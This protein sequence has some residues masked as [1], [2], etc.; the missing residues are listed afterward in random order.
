MSRCVRRSHA[1]SSSPIRSR[2]SGCSTGRGL[3]RAAS[4]SCVDV[5]W[6]R[7]PG[8]IRRDRVGAD[9]AC[10]RAK[11]RR[12]GA[13]APRRLSPTLRSRRR[14][15]RLDEAGRAEASDAAREL[16]F[17]LRPERASPTSHRARRRRH[18][19]PDHAARRGRGAHPISTSCDSPA[20]GSRRRDRVLAVAIAA[21]LGLAMG[22]SLSRRSLAGDGARA[23]A[24]H[25]SRL[26]RRRADAASPRATRRCPR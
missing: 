10:A 4:V 8:R 24:R 22:R 19:A 25:R 20:R 13:T 18:G 16:G 14:R 11:I 1:R 21:A 5:S 2:W 23:P 9:C 12:T 15:E 3:G 26:A 7:Y 17:S 6:R